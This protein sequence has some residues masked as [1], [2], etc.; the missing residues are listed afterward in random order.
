MSA[1]LAVPADLETP[2]LVVDL[3]VLERNLDEM[4]DLTRAAGVELL[5]HAKTHRI[6]EIGRLQVDRGAD[7]L[8][9]AKLGEAE[10]F[11]AAGVTRMT[12]AYPVVGR[13]KAVRA[14]R[15][16]DRVDLTLG[17]DSV[18]GARFLGEVFAADGR[19]VDLVLIVDSGLGRVGVQP[20]EAAAAARAIDAV[21]G[22]QVVGV[23]THEGSVY[24]AADRADLVTR[25]KAAAAL[26]VGAAESIRSAGVPLKT[27]SLGASASA[28][29]AAGEP[30]VTQIRPGI[31]A[32]NDLG[33][34]ALGNATA[35]TCAV[36]VLAT[37]VS[38]PDPY[39]AC[40]DAGS[41]SL[42]QD[43]L[44]AAA[45]AAEYAG[46]GL[47][48]GLPGW[49]IDRLS[50]EHGWLR[51]R[52]PGDPTPLTI[53]QRVQIIPNHVCTVFSSLNEATAIRGGEVE[54]VW[55]TIGPGASR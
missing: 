27:V 36:R 7:G 26:M 29:V 12:V 31:Y 34:V 14:R 33:Q 17:V 23:M 3:D 51:W 43:G 49:R 44:P 42:S 16:A 8:C 9:V 50:E 20:A 52:G 5:P 39:R 19:L 38:H 21:P 6:P 22:V 18:E 46:H 10:A 30:G 2:N 28:R 55:R 45:H 15:L 1:T 4:A 37:V 40:V 47:L 25:S 11:A 13:D 24:A 32:F 41:K 48:V 54:A 53:G 35:R